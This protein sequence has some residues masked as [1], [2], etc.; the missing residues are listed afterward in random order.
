MTSATNKEAGKKVEVLIPV[1]LA[2]GTEAQTLYL[3]RALRSAD[4]SVGVCCYFEANETVIQAFEREGTR[5]S[6]L[7]L[8]PSGQAHRLRSLLRVGRAVFTHLRQTRPDVVHVQYLAPGLVSVLAARAA[9]VP[10]VLATVHQPGDPYGAMARLSLRLAARLSTAF[11]CVSRAVERSWFGDSALFDPSSVGKRRHFT[12]YDCVDVEQFAHGAD[13]ADTQAIR[14][15]LGL[16]GHPVVGVV[17]RLRREK[18]HAALLEALS[19]VVRSVPDV[20]LVVVGDGQERAHLEERARGLG[21]DGHIVWLG[22]RRPEELPGLYGVMDVVAIPSQFEGFGLV[23]VEAM[24]AARPVVAF[25]TGGLTEIVADGISGKLVPP[26]DRI[27][28]AGA[29]VGLIT[30]RKGAVEKGKAGR[31]IV[32]SGFSQETFS[33]LIL[34]AYRRYAA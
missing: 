14:E 28:F 32:Q 15:E 8:G 25:A 19:L 12:L 30:D 33:S 34:S 16:A 18:G 24:A 31:R 21:L 6:L 2:G 7:R 26:G 4:Y 17:G 10:A 5:V 1:L 20:T 22:A 27:A 23:A 9:R 13:Q 11:F 29:L 3:V